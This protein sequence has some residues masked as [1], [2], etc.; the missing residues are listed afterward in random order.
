MS[1][2]TEAAAEP[3]GPFVARFDDAVDR[4]LDRLRGNPIADRV[5]YGLS[6]AANFSLLWYGVALVR[7][8]ISPR[9]RRDVLRLAVCIGLESLV[10]NQGL[11]QLFGRGRPDRTDHVDPH[12][13]R[14]PST[15]SFPSGHASSA[16]FAASLL[17]DTD[18]RRRWL[19]CGLAGLVATSR[20]YVRIH[21]ASDVAG[22][23]L[24]GWLLAR[25]ARRLWRL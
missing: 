14:L 13:L 21:H 3:F 2:A 16:V 20:P 23:A 18:P 24:A 25:V 6:E 19:W 15:T 12:R 17:I 1:A 22:G 5:F 11:K 4:T 9:Y 7:A 8:A 10:V